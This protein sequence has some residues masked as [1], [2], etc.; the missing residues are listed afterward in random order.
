MGSYAVPFDVPRLT[1]DEALRVLGGALRFGIVPLL[2][3]VEDML[4]E[5]G[6]P[7]LCYQSIQIAGTNGK[8]STSRYVASILT[9]SGLSVALYTSP[10]LVRYTERMEV[11]GR[12]VDDDLFALGLSAARES[13]RRVNA[14]RS[15]RGERP[16]DVTEFDLL[17]VAACVVY[18]LEGVDVAVFEVGMGGRWD[19]TSAVKSTRS[20]AVTGIGLDHTRILGDTLEAIA[21]E[22]AA[23]IRS[24]RTCVLGTGT[25]AT[26][27]VRDVMREQC[28]REAV[29]PWV[30]RE[31]ADSTPWA[32]NVVEFGIEQRPGRLGD[33]L[34]LWVRTP[35]ASY[36]GLRA[37]KP[38][39]QAQNI[40]CAVAVAEQFLGHPLDAESV[41]AA[42]LACP[43]PGR[44]DVVREWP[45]ALVDACHNPQSVEVFLK[46]LDE[47][48]P[49]VSRRP[50]LV[51]A[52]LADKDVE[53]MARLLSAAFPSVVATQT[54]SH[55]ALAAEDLAELFRK[56]GCDLRATC[57]SV[58]EAV[59]LVGDEPF[60]ACG[61]ITTAG[62]V[63]GLLRG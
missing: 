23:V 41:R 43:T 54:A 31:V 21:G 14:G 58:V 27:G 32:A 19:A 39:Y 45:L 44:F 37:L 34:R 59:T 22:K 29:E 63:V 55:R 2:E 56:Y 16:Y 1:Y 20:V 5:L 12:P 52:M 30:V 40:A 33:P 48:E 6:D 10:E 38:S 57:D 4:A 9:K 15:A 17:T 47:V 46:A 24:G 50:V 36:E 60:V 51:C 13:A 18:A 25:Y 61:S 49:N 42:V 26:D 35:N 11:G 53:G 62:A 28:E 7:D 3:T 8:T